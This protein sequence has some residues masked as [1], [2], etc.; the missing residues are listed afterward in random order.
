MSHCPFCEA[1]LET[2]LVCTSCETLLP[3]SAAISPFA[4]FGLPPSWV[5]VSDDL[6]RRLLKYSRL[7][8]PDF[9]VTAA[10]EQRELAESGSA[11]LNSAHEVLSDPL[12]RGEW[13]VRHLGGP[14]EAEERQMPQAFLVEVLD[15][16]ETLED[17]AGA[18][19]GSP[20]W[21]ALEELE[22][23]LRA[24]R[25]GLFETI[26]GLLQPLPAEGAEALVEVRRSLNAARY[27][28]KSLAELTNLRLQA[29]H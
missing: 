8:H 7:M 12:A 11:E 17:A 19:A 1:P 24:R 20:E 21:Q 4:V 15:W 5:V 27:V 23:T 22:G 10:P 18:A 2:P 13:L 14:S 28:D 3:T 16:N 25:E 29:A 6:E 9:F 26:R